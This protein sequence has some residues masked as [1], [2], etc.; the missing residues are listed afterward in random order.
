MQYYKLF[1]NKCFFPKKKITKHMESDRYFFN[2]RSCNTE[3]TLCQP[4]F[5]AFFHHF[6]TSPH[7]PVLLPQ[8]PPVLY[9]TFTRPRPVLNPS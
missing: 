7:T 6:S 9:P 1:S 8:T 3:K 5:S 2:F 4:S